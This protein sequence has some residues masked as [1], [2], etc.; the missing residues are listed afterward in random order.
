MER[1]RYDVKLRHRQLGQLLCLRQAYNRHR[2]GPPLRPPPP[3]QCQR[4]A[5]GR[6]CPVHPRT[7]LR[8]HTGC[9]SP[10]RRICSEQRLHSHAC[11]T[12]APPPARPPHPA[13]HPPPRGPPFTRALAH[14]LT[15][16]CRYL[17]LSC[18]RIP[19]APAADPAPLLASLPP[20]LPA[21]LPACLRLLLLRRRCQDLSNGAMIPAVVDFPQQ[22]QQ[23]QQ[24]QPPQQEQ[25]QQ[26]QEREQAAA[27]GRRQDPLQEQDQLQQAQELERRRRRT[28][29]TDKALLTPEELRQKLK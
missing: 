16:L 11:R 22:Q 8:L 24:R 9:C 27:A 4:E 10:T 18:C 14:E 19:P 23:Q 3:S 1:E 26:G 15:L 12:L 5:Q 20:C 29:F 28:G 2:K 7:P 21:R 25:P 6:A 17:A 13:R